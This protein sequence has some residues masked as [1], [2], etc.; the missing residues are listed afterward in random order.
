MNA[1]GPGADA[2]IDV[3]DLLK[4]AKRWLLWRSEPGEAGKKPRKVPYYADGGRRGQTDCPEDWDRLVSFNDALIAFAAGGYTGLGFALGPDNNGGF[5]QGIDLDDIADHFG[6]EF[7]AEDLPGYTEESPSGRGVHAMGYGRRFATLGSNG[8]GIEAYAQG[9]F[10]AVT[11]SKVGLGVI[12]C[13]ADFVRDELVWRHASQMPKATP[14]SEDFGAFGSTLRAAELR[15]ALHWIPSDD[16]EIWI[17]LGHA[18]RTL[19]DFGKA[20]W[21]EWSQKSSKYEAKAAEAAWRSFKPVRISHRAVFAE[22]RRYGWN[23]PNGPGADHHTGGPEPRAGRQADRVDDTAPEFSEEALALDFA[24]R[25]SHRLRFVHAWGRWMIFN[26]QRWVPDDT[27]DSLDEVRRMSR[28]AAAALAPEKLPAARKLASANTATAVE[29]LARTD[30]R[31]AA[32]SA[33]WDADPWLLNTS[34]GV[35]D[36]RSG[37]MRPHAPDDYMTKM[38]TVAPSGDCPLWLAFIKRITDGNEA[39]ATF[40]QRMFGY[41][42]TGDTSLQLFFFAHGTGANGKSVLLSTVA[43]IIGDYHRA[44]PIETFTATASDRHPTDVAGLMGARLVTCVETE[45]GRRWQESRIKS[46]TGGDK[47][48]ARFM[49]QDYFEFSP[50]FKLLIAGNH[51]P[52]LRSVDEAIRRRLKLIPFTVTI[53][54]E[55]RDPALMEKLRAEYSGILAWAIRGCLDWQSK[56]LGVPEVVDQATDAY[57]EAEDAVGAWLAESCELSP[58]YEEPT[59]QLFSSW[60]LWADTAGEYVGSEKSLAQVLLARGFVSCRFK[61]AR[62]FRGLRLLKR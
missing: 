42:L 60:K 61:K 47:I 20:L 62:G 44:A 7:V 18:L 48:A 12:T 1:F 54:P 43:A 9:R 45:Q 53:P 30:R 52:G 2:Y 35:V 29:R 36:L 33:I 34:G 15:D 32:S 24:G 55:E 27:L 41:M 14:P 31:L 58:N 3:P 4:D 59:Q 28:E 26:G 51:K 21:F 19:D 46:L 56:G 8:N 50:Q 16:R 11:G 13:L 23:G 57:L 37:A 5:W 10:F 25:H 49:R 38:T 6:L 40:I 22:A 17:R 39:L